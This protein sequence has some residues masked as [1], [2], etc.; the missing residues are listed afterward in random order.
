MRVTV[1]GGTTNPSQCCVIWQ[2]NTGICAVADVNT[3][4][5]EGCA[6]TTAVLDCRS[7]VGE[8]RFTNCEVAH[9][10]VVVWRSAV[11]ASCTDCGRHV[12]E[13][14]VVKHV[15]VICACSTATVGECK[16]LCVVGA[17]V[18]N[19][20]STIL[21]GRFVTVNGELVTCT[22]HHDTLAFSN[23]NFNARHDR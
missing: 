3:G 19:C 4:Q 20:D 2:I 8:G 12:D 5:V 21:F 13:V 10:T 14:N 18:G 1:C 11:A 22:S 6:L 23:L 15:A 16:T 7:N 9:V 17:H